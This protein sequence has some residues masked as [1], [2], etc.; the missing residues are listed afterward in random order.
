VRIPADQSKNHIK[1]RVLLLG[2]IGLFNTESFHYCTIKIEK[3]PE[4]ALPY[5]KNSY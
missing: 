5:E 3:N 1:K 2:L 4:K